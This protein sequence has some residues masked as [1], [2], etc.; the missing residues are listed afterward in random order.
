MKPLDDLCQQVQK[1][2]AVRVIGLDS[3]LGI[4]MNRAEHTGCDQVAIARGVGDVA[5]AQKCRRGKQ[6]PLLM[7]SAHQEVSFYCAP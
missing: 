4:S 7:V 2:P 5:G 3:G 6:R 1:G